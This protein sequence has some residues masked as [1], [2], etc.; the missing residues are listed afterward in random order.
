MHDEELTSRRIRMHGTCHGQNTRGVLQIVGKTILCKFSFDGVTGTTHTGSL[1]ASALDHETG[2][3]TMKDFSIVEMFV[4]QAD[5]VV[6]GIWCDF[7]IEFALHH[8]TVF[9]CDRNNRIRHDKRS[10]FFSFFSCYSCQN[11]L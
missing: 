9:H 1:R 3:N 7:R 5:K 10:F 2:N 11:S 8:I 4:C 6:D